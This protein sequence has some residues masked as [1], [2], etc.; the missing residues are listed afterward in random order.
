M[1]WKYLLFKSAITLQPGTP[2]NWIT[3]REVSPIFFFFR[4]HLQY[5]RGVPSRPECNG[6][7]SLLRRFTAMF[8]YES[9][10][11]LEFRN[12][13]GT[14]Q[15]LDYRDLNDAVCKVIYVLPGAIIGDGDRKSWDPRAPMIWDNFSIFRTNCAILMSHIRADPRTRRRLSRGCCRVAWSNGESWETSRD[16]LA[17][18]SQR[19]Q[20]IR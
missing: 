8:H 13:R 19:W 16:Y 3:R 18:F 6:W 17:Y 1:H 12:K 15:K 2:R 4:V 11:G 14:V 5:L 7:S 9:V 10:F 20:G